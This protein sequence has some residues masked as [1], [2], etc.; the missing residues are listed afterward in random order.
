MKNAIISPSCGPA[1]GFNIVLNTNGFSTDSNVSWEMIDKKSNP[2]LTG[3][4]FTNASGGFN[5][6]TF[7]DDLLPGDYIINIFDDDDLDSKLD[8]NGRVF[9]S[10]ISLPCS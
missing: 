8:L 6:I 7:V 1:E 2:V 10:N 9:Q 4:F 3:Y 5:E